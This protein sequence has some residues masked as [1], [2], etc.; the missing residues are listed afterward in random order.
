MRMVSELPERTKWRSARRV[1]LHRTRVDAFR[2]YALLVV[3]LGH[4][5]F[6][7]GRS[8]QTGLHT[9]ELVA[10]VL[11]R[12]AVP[13]FF[14]FAGEHLGPRL[15]RGRAP[16]AGW[17]Y[18]RRLA[19]MFL[20]A[21][22]LYWAFDI[23]K[24]ARHFGL[25]GGIVTFFT[26]RSGDPLHLLLYGGRPHLWFLVALMLSVAIA[27]M[28]LQRSRV[29]TFVLGSAVLYG[30]GLAAG[31]YAVTFGVPAGRAWF[32]WLLQSPLFFALGV[33]FALER[34]YQPRPRLALLLIA[35]GVAMHATE[36]WWLTAQGASP[37]RL[38]MLLGTVP[39][40][41]GV[42]MIAF[43]PGASWLDR[44]AGPFVAYVPMVYLIHMIFLEIMLPPPGRFPEVAT[45]ILLPLLTTVLSFAAAA[46][47]VR[48]LGRIRR[49][50]RRVARGVPVP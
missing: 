26:R 8:S 1:G 3:I 42:A 18:S 19:L 7:I 11:G 12:V 6:A 9:I 14:L 24:L 45:R 40:T 47:I 15:L 34:T 39:Y 41:A 16:G 35:I 48:L 28:V 27:G 33:L 44:L 37:F 50:R 46:G 43:A 20:A 17:Q 30:I 36:V 13:L 29:R 22:A 49:G 10:N 32:E 5:D 21:S 38:G 25:V 2:V 4:S 23:A 31:P